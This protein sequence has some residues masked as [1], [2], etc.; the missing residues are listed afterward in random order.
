M[1]TKGHETSFEEPQFQ[2]RKQSKKRRSLTE[3]VSW[4]MDETP[5]VIS[6][7]CRLI[8]FPFSRID[9]DRGLPMALSGPHKGLKGSRDRLLGFWRLSGLECD[10]G[11]GDA[12]AYQSCWS[13]TDKVR[14]ELGEA[15]PDFFLIL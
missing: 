8:C 14:K 12:H 5:S 3:K 1:G 4:Y 11:I 9:P 10:S 15:L 13:G 6:R 7:L 2:G